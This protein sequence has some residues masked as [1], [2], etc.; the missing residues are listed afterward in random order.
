[1]AVHRV[2]LTHEDYLAMPDDGRRH[3]ILDGEVAVSAT[4]VTLH[5]LIVGNLYRGLRS[6]VHGRR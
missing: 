1:M 2:M 5:Q 3:E 4:P 6:H